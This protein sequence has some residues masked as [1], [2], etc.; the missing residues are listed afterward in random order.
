MAN[1]SLGSVTNIWCMLHIPP[2]HACTHMEKKENER[3]ICE[4]KNISN[5]TQPICSAKDE[6]LHSQQDLIQWPFA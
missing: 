1:F 5:I 3:Q 2:P 4:E 6:L